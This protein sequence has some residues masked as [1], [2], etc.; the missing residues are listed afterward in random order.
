MAAKVHKIIQLL[1][2]NCKKHGMA[3]KKLGTSA[4]KQTKKEEFSPFF[5]FSPVFFL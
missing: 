5:I 3:G 4:T 2:E 1:H